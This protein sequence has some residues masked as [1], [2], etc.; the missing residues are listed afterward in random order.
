MFSTPADVTV[1]EN[2]PTD[3]GHF[4]LPDPTLANDAYKTAPGNDTPLLALRPRVASSRCV[5][6]LRPRVASMP[7]IVRQYFA[8]SSSDIAGM[9]LANVELHKYRHL[10]YLAAGITSLVRSTPLIAAPDAPHAVW[11]RSGFYR[12]ITVS[13]TGTIIRFI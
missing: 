12:A 9:L 3:L 7:Y 5:L 10:E 11:T 8:D 4:V 1:S 13:Y 6:A 2:L